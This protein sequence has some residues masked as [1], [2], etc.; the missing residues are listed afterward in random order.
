MCLFSVA[1]VSASDVNDT[2]NADSNDNILYDAVTAD[3]GIVADHNESS[4]SEYNGHDGWDDLDKD[5]QNLQLDDVYNIKHDYTKPDNIKNI[6]TINKY[7]RWNY[8][9][10]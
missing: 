1:S 6:K 2:E 3:A 8:S 7:S 10:L 5:F 4:V 9:G